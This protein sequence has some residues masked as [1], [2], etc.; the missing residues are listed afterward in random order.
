M[1]RRCDQCQ[2]WVKQFTRT[3]HSDEKLHDDDVAGECRRLPPVLSREPVNYESEYFDEQSEFPLVIASEWCGEWRAVEM[4]FSIY[5][6]PLTDREYEALHL[7]GIDTVNKLCS[8]SYQE[9]MRIPNIGRLSVRRIATAL[10]SL[11]HEVPGLP[12]RL[13]STMPSHPRPLPE[14]VERSGGP[15]RPTSGRP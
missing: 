7:N 10:A 14:S 1:K 15:S 3:R 5:E 11:G 12:P 4:Y 2:Y 13:L 8:L 6:L 9:L